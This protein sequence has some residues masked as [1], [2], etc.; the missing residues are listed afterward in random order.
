[1]N[2]QEIEQWCSEHEEK[3]NQYVAWLDYQIGFTGVGT[4]GLDQKP[5]FEKPNDIPDDVKNALIE[6]GKE[7]AKFKYD[8]FRES[9]KETIDEE[10]EGDWKCPEIG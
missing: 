9:V 2:E 6:A 7:Y 8:C 5:K 1:V 4:T 3:V 10:I